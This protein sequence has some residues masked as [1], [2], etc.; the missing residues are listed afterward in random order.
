MVE[1]VV[2]LIPKKISLKYTQFELVVK[3]ILMKMVFGFGFDFNKHLVKISII[4]K[5]WFW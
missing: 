1:H 3:S 4:I 2:S 5:L